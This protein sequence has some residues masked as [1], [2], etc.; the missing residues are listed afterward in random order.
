MVTGTSVDQP[1]MFGPPKAQKVEAEPLSVLAFCCGLV[2][3]G[4]SLVKSQ[5]TAI[6]LVVLAG[7]GAV[8]VLLLKSKLDGQI[9]KQA[10]GVI[11]AEYEVGFWLV[12]VS[13]LAG[14]ALNVIVLSDQTNRTRSP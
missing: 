13:Y 5:K 4:I 12:L 3:L 2:G 14:V 1:Q 7:M 9:L 10:G 11:H 6:F 8:A